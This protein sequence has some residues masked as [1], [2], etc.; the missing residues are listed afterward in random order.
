MPAH[1]HGRRL[2]SG[3]GRGFF[4]QSLE[5]IG[6]VEGQPE[7]AETA[8][9][10]VIRPLDG[11]L[12]VPRYRLHVHVELADDGLEPALR[13]RAGPTGHEGRCYDEHCRGAE[14]AAHGDEHE[15]SGAIQ[16]L[17]EH[18]DPRFFVFQS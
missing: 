1:S 13:A 10:R 15:C 7:V 2:R 5:Q 8:P 18:S 17:A 11:T 3:T 16:R 14:E 9:S 4:H 12:E 6:Q